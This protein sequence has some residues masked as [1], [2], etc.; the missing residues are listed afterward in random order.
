MQPPNTQAT[1]AGGETA[2]IPVTN[3]ERILPLDIMRGFVLCGILL[4][5]IT[6]F[7][8]A[9]A[10]MNPTVSGG[11][12]G[13]SL[14][15][16]ITTNMFFEGTMR[17]LFSLLFGVGA[18][19]ILDRLSKKD[20]GIKA[21]DIYFRRLL[22]MLVFGLIHGY[23]L[24]WTGEILYDYAL[25]GL[26]LFSFRNMAP[27]KLIL[28]ALL[29]F[30]IGTFWTY[31]DYTGD[32]KLVADVALA[33]TK[34]AQGQELSKELK[35][36]TAKWRARRSTPSAIR[37]RASCAARGALVRSWGWG[38]SPRCGRRRGTWGRSCVPAMRSTRWRR[39]AHS[40][41]SGRFRWRLRWRRSC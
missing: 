19:I 41:S 31:K 6:G 16:W 30:A 36:A 3:S 15:A 22:W 25:M 28:I 29:L 33:Q 1:P 17:A 13:W 39:A 14:Y 9:N 8:L 10:Y 23:L 38:S 35:E 7:G 2:F 5:N 40:G 20:A 21:A 26:L 12:T 4:M 27:K 18:F 32:K 37:S 11:S 24:L 34:T